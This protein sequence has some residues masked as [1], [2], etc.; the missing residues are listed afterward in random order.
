MKYVISFDLRQGAH[1]DDLA[2]ARRILT[3]MGYVGNVWRTGAMS[4]QLPRCAAV[5]RLEAHAGAHD[6]LRTIAAKLSKAGLP[7][8]RLVV[9]A[10]G[11]G[12]IATLDDGR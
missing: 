10:V 6:E 12:G 4:D 2:R 5:G 9:A 8:A 3:E 1:P 7:F 11:V